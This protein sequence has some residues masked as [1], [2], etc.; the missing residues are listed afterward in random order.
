MIA[1]VTLVLLLAPRR[2]G[3]KGVLL[4]EDLGVEGRADTEH[5]QRNIYMRADGGYSI[6]LRPT[7]PLPPMIHKEYREPQPISVKV[8]SAFK[9]P[10]GPTLPPVSIPAH[11]AAHAGVT[12]WTY[13]ASH[14]RPLLGTRKVPHP[15]WNSR[16][17]AAMPKKWEQEVVEGLEG[18]RG[19][20]KTTSNPSVRSTL[21]PLASVSSLAEVP[22]VWEDA[23]VD[24][25]DGPREH[26]VADVLAGEPVEEVKGEDMSFL[27]SPWMDRWLKV[28]L[29]TF[30]LVLSSAGQ[31]CVACLL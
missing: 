28:G 17:V 30:S 7:A 11:W 4:D 3:E 6:V 9:R 24:V 22:S 31:V 8:A 10:E 16:T 15:S 20:G 2:A 12:S 25:Q 23:A 13:A 27:D 29:D 18:R 26:P 14:G 1:V 21:R 5:T 19:V